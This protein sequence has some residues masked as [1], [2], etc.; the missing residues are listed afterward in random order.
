MAI[1]FIGLRGNVLDG[2]AATGLFANVVGHEP[3]AAPVRDGLTAAIW[4]A[5]VSPIQSSGLAALSMLVELQVRIFTSMLGEPQ[6]A[7]D[8]AVMDAADK[9]MAYLASEFTMGSTARYIDLLGSDSE[10]LRCQT[11]YLTQDSTPFR[12]MDVFVPILIN[13]AYTLTA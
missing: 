1:D 8:P 13:D 2:L 3:K 5:E 7:I 4:N 6:D 10:G 12:V 9:L 11:G